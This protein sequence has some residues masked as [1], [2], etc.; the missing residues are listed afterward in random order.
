MTNLIL[1]W[2]D[3]ERPV[4]LALLVEAAR[5]GA[6]IRDRL[7]LRSISWHSVISGE[8]I[9]FPLPVVWTG[10]DNPQPRTRGDAFLYANGQ[11]GIIPYGRT[12]EPGLVNVF[13][14]AHPDDLDTVSEIGSIVA[15]SFRAGPGRPFF[16]DIAVAG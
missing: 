11:L 6:A 1:K 16:V 10:F 5:L 12:T 13:G 7:P 14:R 2:S 4:R 8:N 15:E 9:G 3:F